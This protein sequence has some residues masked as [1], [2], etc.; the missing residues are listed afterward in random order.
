MAAPLQ[1]LTNKGQFFIWGEDQDRAFDKL[2]AAFCAAPVLAIPDLNKPFEVISDASLSGT[3]AVLMQDG[4]PCAYTS[5][6]FSTAEKNCHTT[7]QELR[8]VYRALSEWRCYLEGTDC[9]VVT[10]HNALIHLQTQPQ[11]NRR[12]VRWLEFL[13]RFEPGLNWC[14]RPG[15]TLVADPISR[16]CAMGFACFCCKTFCCPMCPSNII[17]VVPRHTSD[18]QTDLCHRPLD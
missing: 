6:K 17:N 10:D 3:G 11:L 4:R 18:N 12:Q 7:D 13:S 15:K 1:L 9:T 16:N 5:K 8:G 2:K 14:Y